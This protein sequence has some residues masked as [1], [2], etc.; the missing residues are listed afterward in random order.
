V[1]AG[2]T[3]TG[4]AVDIEIPRLAWL[5]LAIAS[6]AAFMVALEVTVISLALPEIQAAFSGASFSKMSWIF[7]AYSIGVASLLLVAGW[8]ADLFG[9][10]RMFLTGMAVFAV[11]SFGAGT[12]QS[13]G[14]LI[15]ARALQ[16]IGGAM[17]FPSGLALVLSVFPPA[18]RQLAIGIWAATGGL[19][20]AVGP[21]FGAFLIDAFGWRAVFLINVPVAIV[22]VAAGPGL[23]V[24]SR[25]EG[26]SRRVDVIG[27]P[28]AS[29]GVGV[30]VVGIVQGRDWGWGSWRVVGALAAGAAMLALFVRRS[31]RHPAPLFDLSLLRVRSYRVGLIGSLL[32]SAGFFGSWV[33][34]PSFIQDWWH[35][36]VLRTGLAV[37]P[38]SLIAAL[39]S[40]PIGSVVDRFGHK[41]VV[42]TGGILAALGWAGFALFMDTEPR[43]VIGLLV[44]NVLLGLGMA[45]LFGMLVGASM[46]DIPPNR[47]GM[48]GAGRTT[49]FQLAQALGVAVGVALVGQ[50][51]TASGALSAYRTAWLASAAMLAG[52]AVV[53]LAAYP[54]RERAGRPS[55]NPG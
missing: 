39:L 29:L 26:A 31:R 52:V 40:G 1:T 48:A 33:L 32:F 13:I 12:A 23:L 35:W 5:T 42:A 36:S 41:R 55:T 4:P 30:L 21:S 3:T 28:L 34:L 53:F 51:V 27:V 24:E 14:M 22:A 37:M 10:K 54:A 50:P 49:T 17:L 43:F 7:N 46:R 6:V 19:A 2:P 18:R 20:G 8:A 15:A 25:A 11:G 44:P 47:Y 16:S 9:R 45:V 38:G